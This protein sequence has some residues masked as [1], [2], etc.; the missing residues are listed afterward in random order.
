MLKFALSLLEALYVLY[1]LNLYKT[2]TNFA[3]YN[4]IYFKKYY[5]DKPISMICAAGNILSIMIASYLILREFVSSNNS[6]NL[7]KMKYYNGLI[8]FI[9]LYVSFLNFNITVYL[10]PMFIIE[11]TRLYI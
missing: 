5:Y 3:S 6:N 10:I 1:M 7:C 9:I 4:S 11:F 8:M 2:K